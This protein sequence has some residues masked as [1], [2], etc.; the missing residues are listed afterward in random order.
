MRH[1][2]INF[3][4]SEQRYNRLLRYLTDYIYT[5]TVENN[6][7][8]STHHGP[9]CLAVTGYTPSAVKIVASGPANLVNNLT[10][11]DVVLNL[12]LANKSTSSGIGVD[13][14]A[15]MFKVP[16]GVTVASFLPSSLSVAIGQK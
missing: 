2:K 14:T 12:D 7:A 16:A 6:K 15:A 13:L 8:I 11:A 9:G 1:L 3:D 10:S 4:E 5:V